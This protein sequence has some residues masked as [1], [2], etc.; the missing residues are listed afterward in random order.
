VIY[1]VTVSVDLHT[2]DPTV[3]ASLLG[4]SA[5]VPGTARRIPGGLLVFQSAALNTNPGEASVYR[6][7]LQFGAVHSAMQVGTW[8]YRQLRDVPAAVS[9]GGTLIPLDHRTII[10]TLEQAG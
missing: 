3:A 1:K 5:L 9:I 7:A 2:L 10:S 6:F 8:L 4:T